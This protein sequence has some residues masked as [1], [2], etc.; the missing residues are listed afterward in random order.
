MEKEVESVYEIESTV[1]EQSSESAVAETS[2]MVSDDGIIPYGTI[3]SIDGYQMVDG[4]DVPVQVAF[5]I[6]NIQT[7]ENAYNTLIS[8][9]ADIPNAEEGMEY[10]IVTMNVT[11]SEGTPDTIYIMEN[12]ASLDSAK[13]YFS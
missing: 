12:Y 6:V 4:I 11:Y 5:N 2:L 9:G 3:E 10:I 8:N 7:G 13:L 1:A